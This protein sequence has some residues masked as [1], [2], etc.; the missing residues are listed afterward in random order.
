MIKEKYQAKIS[1]KKS[2][3][4]QEDAKIKNLDLE[5]NISHKWELI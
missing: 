2:F 1:P 3:N 5:S 4:Y